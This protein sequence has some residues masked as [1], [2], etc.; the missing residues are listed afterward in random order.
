MFVDKFNS[1]AF[2]MQG[3]E[4]WMYQSMYVNVKIEGPWC[5]AGQSWE[6]GR[7]VSVPLTG[8]GS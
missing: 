7:I 3:D 8:R 4:Y 6:G 1:Y 5:W 2:Y